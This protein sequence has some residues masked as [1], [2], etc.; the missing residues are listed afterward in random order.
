MS[1]YLN[2]GEQ[3]YKLNLYN[4]EFFG[5]KFPLISLPSHCYHWIIF[6][7][8]IENYNQEYPVAKQNLIKD[9][10]ILQYPDILEENIIGIWNHS[11]S[12]FS[13]G[14]IGNNFEYLE[15]D[16]RFLRLLRQIKIDKIIL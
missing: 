12:F 5:E 11:P 1:E 14:Y 8:E 10:A 15:K 7:I 6:F 2:L 4:F 16:D 9:L 13:S 3:E